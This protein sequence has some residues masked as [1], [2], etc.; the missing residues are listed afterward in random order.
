MRHAVAPNVAGYDTYAT[1]ADPSLAVLTVE[2]ASPDVN[3]IIDG[4]YV[5]PAPATVTLTPGDRVVVLQSQGRNY[6]PYVVRVPE[7]WWS[8]VRF[9]QLA[10]LK[11][12][13]RQRL[14]ARGTGYRQTLRHL[15]PEMA[16]CFPPGWSRSSARLAVEFRRGR[17]ASVHVMGPHGTPAIER[18]IELALMSDVKAPPWRRSVAMEIQM[19]HD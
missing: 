15:R 1:V 6:G 5:G 18:C 12:Q 7:N 14:A 19:Q 16:A 9:D 10:H 2:S 8:D 4:T 17:V 11:L 13:P 3:V